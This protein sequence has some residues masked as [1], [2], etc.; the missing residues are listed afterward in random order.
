MHHF[1]TL[2]RHYNVSLDYL[3]GLTDTPRTIAGDPY[4]VKIIKI[5]QRDNNTNNIH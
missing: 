4:Q 1:I 5:R 2:A 3:A